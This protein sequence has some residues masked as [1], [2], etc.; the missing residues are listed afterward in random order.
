MFYELWRKDAE[1]TSVIHSLSADGSRDS[2]V[3][4]QLA[5]MQLIVNPHTLTS[6]MYFIGSKDLGSKGFL[7]FIFFIRI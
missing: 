6:K 1:K 4:E 2:S 5:V 7:L 3:K